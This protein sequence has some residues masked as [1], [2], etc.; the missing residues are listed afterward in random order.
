MIEFQSVT[1]IGLASPI[2]AITDLLKIT[3]K[4]RDQGTAPA[5]SARVTVPAFMTGPDN[6]TFQEGVRHLREQLLMTRRGKLLLG[7]FGQH[8]HEIQ[9]LLKKVRTIS[10]KWR[11]LHGSGFFHHFLRSV[12]EIEH[13]I[14]SMING[15]SRH[16]LIEELVSQLANHGSASLRR[17]IDKH[18]QWIARALMEFRSVREIPKVLAAIRTLP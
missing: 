7:K 14:P 2:E 12:D 17:D 4:D 6:R 10:N 15:V 16:H 1:K 3:I 9:V 11:E 13:V 5:S 18:G 8:Q